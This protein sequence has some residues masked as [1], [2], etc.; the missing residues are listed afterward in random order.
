MHLLPSTSV[1]LFDST[2]VIRAASAAVVSLIIDDD[3]DD[4]KD[5]HQVVSPALVDQLEK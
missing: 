3:D 4:K 5:K 1:D 2:M